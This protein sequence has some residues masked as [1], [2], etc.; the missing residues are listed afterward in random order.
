MPRRLIT[1]LVVAIASIA[2]AQEPP[3]VEET[4]SVGYV[5]IPFTVIGEKGV[6]ITNLRRGEVGLLVDGKRVTSDMFEKSENAPVS[7]TILLDASGSMALAGKM[8]AA[9]AAIGALLA[10]RRKG[11]DFSLFVFAESEARELVPFTENSSDVTRALATVSPYGKTA[12]FDA[13]ST[14]PE[15]SRLGKNPSRAIILLSDG[16][17]NAS[18]L[19]RED[20][21]RLLQGVAVP[22]YPLGI[23]D[24]REQGKAAH[25]QE[26]L[27]DMG[28]LD[29]VANLTGGKL[30]LGNHPQQIALAVSNI[31]KDLRAQYLI[32]FAPTGQ[33]GVKYRHISLKLDGRVHGV[34][35]RAGYFGTEPPLVAF[36]RERKRS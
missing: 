35:V 9:R 1:G 19:T 2:L 15:R 11:D 33:G 12:F 34:R 13:L 29:A 14:M 27:S 22:I 10:H 18:K 7:F 36:N 3:R 17:D 23:R 30:Y 4:V 28:L 20:L 31:E 6:P 5:M 32:G 21:A 24:P 25:S 8:D 26:E 16:I